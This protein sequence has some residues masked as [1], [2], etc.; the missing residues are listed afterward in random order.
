M[1]KKCEQYWPDAVGQ[2]VVQPNTTLEVTL[3]E[4]M[5]FADYEIRKLE[6][7]DVSLFVCVCM[8]L[9]KGCG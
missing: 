1:Q 6:V 5:P 3:K 8:L 7:L 9:F 4:L 2:T